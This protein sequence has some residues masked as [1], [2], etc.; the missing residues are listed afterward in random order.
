MKTT[1]FFILLLVSSIIYGQYGFYSG[2]E[3][4]YNNH[5]NPT[6]DNTEIESTE[7]NE[8]KRIEYIW[9]PRLF[10]HGGDGGAAA[11][12]IIEYA[13]N[14]SPTMSALNPTWNNVGPAKEIDNNWG[15]GQMGRLCFDPQY[16]N[17]TNQT[18]YV[19]SS[20]GGLWRSEN[21]G[22]F[23]SP[24]TDYLP[25]TAIADVAV[26]FQNSNN[27]FIGTGYAD[28]R[29]EYNNTSSHVNALHTFGIFRSTDYGNEWESISNGF[30]NEF[31]QGGTI[32]RLII[33][34]NNQNQLFVASTRG[35]FRCNNATDPS[36]IWQKVLSFTD[37]AL[38]DF[39]GLA[40][41]PNTPPFSNNVVYASGL[42]IYK[43]IDGGL[44]FFPISIYSLPSDY[45]V[46]RINIAT[47]ISD[48]DRL[49]AYLIGFSE[50]DNKNKLYIYLY[51]ETAGTW[52]NL[53]E[54]VEPS[55]N[56]AISKG[57]N[58]F[59]VSPVQATPPQASGSFFSPV[60]SSKI[61]TFRDV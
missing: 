60:F 41:K 43:S 53:Y 6:S 59:A 21:N 28:G 52:E 57:R 30:I 27:I 44:T 22:Q 55:L 56:D 29:F 54:F 58:A 38:N 2:L 47:T 34:P 1:L 13:E 5:P 14:F 16:N 7:Y 51:H 20:F 39:R 26:S 8:M 37:P 35:V 61:I 36:P 40:F 23:W 31:E 12:A 11:Y 42:D 15:V 24:L 18:I 10:V 48:P 49:Y 46:F 17:T 25:F 4:F 9:A 50:S 45:N 3:E 32:R 19:A 33:N